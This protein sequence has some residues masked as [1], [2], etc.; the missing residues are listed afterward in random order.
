M[1]A[2]TTRRAAVARDVAAAAPAW[3]TARVIVLA[4]LATGWYA[5]NRQHPVTSALRLHEGLLAW[6]GQWYQSIANHGYAGVSRSVLRFF[7]LYPLLGGAVHALSGLPSGVVLA[8]VANA[9]ALVLGALLYRLVLV[10]QGDGDL[11]RRA[12]WFVA[13]VPS[14]FTL[15]LAYPESLAGCLAV[16]VFLAMRTGRWAWAAAFAF[17]AGLTRPVGIL[18]ALPMAV[19]AVRAAGGLHVRGL[20]A[21]LAA[22]AAP[23][24]GTAAY[25]AWV[26]VRFGN[27]LLP[28]QVQEA[29]YLR[30][31]FEDP[32]LALYR[33]G[34]DLLRGRMYPNG[35]HFPWA[36]VF[37]VL[38]I[39]CFRFWPAS[40]GSFAAITLLVALSAQRLGSLER[41]GFGA[42]PVV[43]AL[44][45][46]TARPGID[47]ALV[48]TS[49]AALF[50]YST[51]AFLNLYVP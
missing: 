29:S 23:A 21:R 48:A 40:Y 12:A 27:G 17:L 16:G 34:I 51:L 36:V 7:P 31:R 41:Y 6:D 5:F 2:G 11:A 37:I 15:V 45:S 38:V 47:R 14:A 18:L 32:A 4:A 46:V 26:Q 8:V 35:M 25:L 13:I 33:S 42:F 50:G 49:A 19:E 22:A 28:A 39:V 9:G 24:A 43:L 1:A 3:L 30:G 10:E 20:L 44:A